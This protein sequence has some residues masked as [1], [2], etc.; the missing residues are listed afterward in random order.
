MNKVIITQSNYIPWKGYFTTMRK[1]THFVAYDDMQYT[2]RDWRNRNKIIMPNGPIWLSIPVKVSGKFY[3]KINETEISDINWAKE[4]WNLIECNYKKAPYFKEYNQY[5]KE[6]YLN[7]QSTN[8]SE[9]NMNFLKVCTQLLNIDIKFMDSREFEL[10]GDRT[11]K[12]VNICKD[13][14]ADQYFT[15]PAAK[16]YMD[17]SLFERENIKVTYYDL[18]NFPEYKQQWNGFEHGVSILDMFFNLGANTIDYF[19]KLENNND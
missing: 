3:Q 16:A 10:V 12:L 8:L 13:L 19:N 11:E 4:H 7:S 18:T 15:G 5:F 2:K 9:I 17:E 1:A 14:K 6:L